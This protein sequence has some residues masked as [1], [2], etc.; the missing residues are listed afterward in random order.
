MRSSFWL[1][2]VDFSAAHFQEV[3]VAVGKQI[4]GQFLGIVDLSHRSDGIGAVVRADDQRLGLIIR[5]TADSEKTLHFGSVAFKFGAEAGALNVVD[6]AVKPLL[7]VV[8]DQ[9][10]TARAQM[11]M[12]IRSVKQIKNTIVSGSGSE[13][14]S[15]NYPP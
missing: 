9:P 11:R 12:V 5:N 3:R 7:F 13:K 8:Y 15:H 1:I 14:T 10:G 6:C 2:G 4:L